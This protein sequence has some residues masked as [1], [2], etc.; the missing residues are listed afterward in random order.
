MS[1]TKRLTYE[2]LDVVERRVYEHTPQLAPRDA[3][4]HDHIIVWP[5]R[6]QSPFKLFIAELIKIRSDSRNDL[7]IEICDNF[8]SISSRWY[9]HYSGDSSSVLA[10]DVVHKICNDFEVTLL[11]VIEVLELQLIHCLFGEL[12]LLIRA[13]CLPRRLR[14][15]RS[16]TNRGRCRLAI[17]MHLYW[18]RFDISLC[19]SFTFRSS[20][21]SYLIL[22]RRSLNFPLLRIV[23]IPRPQFRHD[24]R[25]RKQS[26]RLFLY[27]IWI[28][29][30]S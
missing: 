11:K 4:Y 9:S 13:D 16:S 3:S 19:V 2:E 18:C 14:I 20:A 29:S 22:C 24:S 21:H 26:C 30:W 27:F 12:F 8:C 28:H 7:M 10:W 17:Q 1:E 15:A 23:P 25:R 5:H 6:H